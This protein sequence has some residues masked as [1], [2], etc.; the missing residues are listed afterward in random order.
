[1]KILLAVLSVLV[2]SVA[3]I[4]SRLY[5][6]GKD[7]SPAMSRDDWM[8]K[9]IHG[10]IQHHG[11]HVHNV[12]TVTKTIVVT[13]VVHN[14]YHNLVHQCQT[15]TYNARRKCR[16]Q[17]HSLQQ[18]VHYVEHVLHTIIH[19]LRMW[20]YKVATCRHTCYK[21]CSTILNYYT[22]LVYHTG[23]MQR[24]HFVKG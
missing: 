21:S 4:P 24:K 7:V 20:K 6:V 15:N 3:A 2:A 8:H 11:Q 19:Q 18:R 9:W 13:T 23:H 17:A 1:M 16:Y 5:D 14:R 22:G 10:H 12:E